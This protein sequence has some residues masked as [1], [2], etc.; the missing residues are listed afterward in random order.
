MKNKYFFCIAFI[1][2]LLVV[3]ANAQDTLKA[4]FLNP[5]ASAHPRAWWHWTKSNISKEGITKDLEWMKRIGIA[6]MQLADVNSGGGQTTPVKLEF[7]SPQWLDAVHYAA[8]EAE[9][10]K[11]EMAVFSSAGWSLTGGTWVKPSQAMKKLVW[12]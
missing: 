7:G 5:P 3:N 6:G 11:L 10:L 4:G 2:S 8:N 9:R 1:S 12:S